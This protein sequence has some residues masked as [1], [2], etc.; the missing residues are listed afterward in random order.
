MET[1][2]KLEL[3]EAMDA[4]LAAWRKE[5]SKT[6]PHGTKTG[7]KLGSKTVKTGPVCTQTERDTLGRIGVLVSRRLRKRSLWGKVQS[8]IVED[9]IG[10][11]A[12]TKMK[13]CPEPAEEQL[14]LP[15]F[16]HLPKTIGTGKYRS[17]LTQVSISRFLVYEQ[18]YQSTK[19]R[20]E[21]V[22]EN[23]HNLAELIRPLLKADPDMSVGEAVRRAQAASP[24]L[25][26]VSHG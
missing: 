9:F 2:L 24:E 7:P 11:M 19:E 6:G 23:L 4:A 20:N 14:N 8:A 22:A 26:V 13:L 12:K 10:H 3:M 25:T 1:R 15:G 5:T 18:R 21:K 17:R 16:E